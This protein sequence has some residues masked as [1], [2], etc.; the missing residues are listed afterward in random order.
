M[1]TKEYAGISVEVNDEIYMTD[2]SEWNEEIGRAIA[3]EDGIELTD[4]H[5]RVINILHE[6][7]SAK[8]QLPTIRSL[9]KLGVETKRLYE[10]FPGGPIKKASRIAGYLKPASCV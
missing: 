8:G 3:T 1:A 2:H 10:L 6:Q 9:K 7:M 4:D 5:W